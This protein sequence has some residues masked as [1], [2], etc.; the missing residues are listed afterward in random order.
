[1][2]GESRENLCVRGGMEAKAEKEAAQPGQQPG[3]QISA[4]SSQQPSLQALFINEL[5]TRQLL[6]VACARHLDGSS[7]HAAHRHSADATNFVDV[8]EGQT[9][10]LV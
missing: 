6:L 2:P 1:M 9:Q 4:C 5:T 3:G 10:G 8:L 7:L